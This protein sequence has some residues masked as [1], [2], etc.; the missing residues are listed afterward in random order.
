ME[1]QVKTLFSIGASKERGRVFSPDGVMATIPASCYKGP[2]KVLVDTNY[3]I[4]L[5]GRTIYDESCEK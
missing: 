2:P 1:T 5:K 3:T 4:R